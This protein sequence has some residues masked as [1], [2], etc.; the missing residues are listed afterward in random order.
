MDLEKIYR[1]IQ[2][3]LASVEEQLKSSLVKT[4]NDKIAEINRYLYASPGKRIRPALVILSAK[5]ISA[6]R[7]EKSINK[8]TS[9]A[10]AIELI[11]M[12]SLIHDDVIDHS[13]L[14]HNK[15]TVN[16]KWGQEAA[17]ALG[18]YLYSE[19]FELI[20]Q[21]GNTDILQCITSATKAMCEGEFLQVCERDDFE[22]LK[23]RYFL[24]VKKK[25]ASLF[26]ASCQVGSLISSTVKPS[27]EALSEYGL[28]FGI[29]FQIIDDHFDIVGNRETL[30]KEPGQDISVGEATLPLIH[31]FESVSSE[32]R[33][34]LKKLL[35]SKENKG[36]LQYIRKMYFEFEAEKA[37]KESAIYFADLAKDSLR[38]LTPSPYQESLSGLVDFILSGKSE[39]NAP[40]ID[41]SF[42]MY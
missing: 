15:S 10:A 35:A 33:E 37:T 30:G 18:D 7:G 40:A 17:I 9:I 6:E 42:L 23:E 25:T 38:R 2:K 26:A 13:G 24:I 29:T 39:S 41:Q 27:Q 11:H 31:L 34:E 20:A 16:A 19:A 1:P 12:A 22:L 21:H 5:A 36:A 8:V 32:V 14:R 28:N 4:N 3:E